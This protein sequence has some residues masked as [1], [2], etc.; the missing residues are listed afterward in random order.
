MSANGTPAFAGGPPGWPVM[1]MTPLIACA[2]RSKPGR[3]DQGPVWPKPEML[4]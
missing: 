4:A 2:I 3:S 1:L